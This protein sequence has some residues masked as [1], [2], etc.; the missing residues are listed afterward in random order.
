MA[1]D[2][3]TIQ[4]RARRLAEQAVKVWKPPTL[5]ADVLETYHPKVEQPS[6]YTLDD[7][8]QL[9]EGRP[10]RSLFEEFGKEVLYVVRPEW[11]NEPVL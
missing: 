1:G 7:H 11:T 10:M 8:V 6:G 5:Q 2:Q 9:A 4:Q 3:T